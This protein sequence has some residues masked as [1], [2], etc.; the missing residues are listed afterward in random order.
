MQWLAPPGRSHF[1]GSLLLLICAL[2]LLIPGGPVA[3]ESPPELVLDARAALIIVDLQKSI[4]ARP[5]LEPV[6][7]VAE[8]A[9]RLADGFRQQRLPVVLVR[10]ATQPRG[11]IQQPHRSSGPPDPAR[12]ELLPSLSVQRSDHVIMKE[13][14]SAFSHTD[15]ARY[16]KRHD[17][18]HVVILGY[19]TSIAVES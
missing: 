3:S 7:A 11:R 19:S 1:T 17:V 14:W 18:T 4:L 16:L 6:D 9:R 10:S 13:G 12:S 8:R 15:L 5:T 2:A